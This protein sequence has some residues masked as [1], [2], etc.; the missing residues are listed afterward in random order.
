VVVL[1]EVVRRG[2]SVSGSTAAAWVASRLDDGDQSLPDGQYAVIVADELSGEIAVLTDRLATRAVFVA[3]VGDAVMITSE[4]KALVAAGLTPRL[5]LQAWAELL[6]F[7]HTLADR[8][9]LEGARLV[10]PATTLRVDA[11]GGTRTHQRERY[12]LEPALLRDREGW[13]DEFEALL[14][15]AVTERVDHR[16]A[17]ALSGGLDSR[18]IAAQLS[19]STRAVT[20]GMNGSEEIARARA[21]A[22]ALGLRQHVITLEPGYIGRGAREVVWL[23]EGRIRA[24]H[25]H[26]LALARLRAT[27]QIDA[28][29]IGYAGDAVVRWGAMTL[30]N[31]FG[32]AGGTS[33]LADAVYA[34][35]C[36]ALDDRMVGEVLTPVFAAEVSGRARWGIHE[37]FSSSDGPSDVRRIQFAIDHV[38]PHK[39]LPGVNL[40]ADELAARDPYVDG[41]LLAFLRRVPRELRVGGE[42]QRALLRRRPGLA[43]VPNPKDG[44]APAWTGRLERAARFAVRGRRAAASHLDGVLRG[45]GRTPRRGLGDY[46]ADLRAAEG[47]TMLSV[48]LEERT[49]DRGQIREGPVRAMIEETLTGRRPHT[50]VLGM[51]VTLELFQRQFVDRD[52]VVLSAASLRDDLVTVGRRATR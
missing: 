10:G 44:I 46:A 7:E 50:Q 16:T 13:V 33:S 17:I 18:C 4:L 8:S 3:R 5:D 30:S 39:I 11:H 19:G 32:F 29:A 28:L 40:Y 31:S 25:A 22:R 51:L 12:L 6:A 36:V 23:A 37:V 20:F 24:F 45:I 34:R 27:H 52:S 41:E 38:Y 49:L 26:H 21:V 48:L 35:Q 1:G 14:R 47:A 43:A 42:L 15:E 2:R 9:P